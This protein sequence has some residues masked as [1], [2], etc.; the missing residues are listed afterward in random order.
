L[1][2]NTFAK[3]AAL[4][5]NRHICFAPLFQN[6]LNDGILHFMN[7]WTHLLDYAPKLAEWY[8]TY[9][10]NAPSEKASSKPL[11]ETHETKNWESLANHLQA[12]VQKRTSDL[13]ATRTKTGLLVAS[14]AVVL[15]AFIATNFQNDTLAYIAAISLLLSLGLALWAMSLHKTPHTLK[16]EDMILHLTEHPNMSRLHFQKWLAKS[17]ASADAVYTETCHQLDNRVSLSTVLLFL[18]FAALVASK[19]ST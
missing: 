10:E 12:N 6:V 11:S 1:K 15:L 19:L 17:Y 16:P 2:K 4:K 13:T 3:P 14:A 8:S 7:I 9:A 18:S 5:P